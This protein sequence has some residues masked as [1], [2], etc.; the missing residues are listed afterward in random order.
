MQDGNGTLQHQLIATLDA[1]SERLTWYLL[2]VLQQTV[3]RGP[4]TPTMVHPWSSSEQRQD[5]VAT[6]RQVV[7]TVQCQR[8]VAE[9][10]V[11]STLFARSVFHENN[12]N[13]NNNNNKEI[14]TEL[15]FRWYV[16][17]RHALFVSSSE[18]ALLP[19]NLWEL[20]LAPFDEQ[21]AWFR[22]NG[23]KADVAKWR[24]QQQQQQQQQQLKLEQSPYSPNRTG[25][26]NFLHHLEHQSDDDALLSPRFLQ[27]WQQAMAHPVEETVATLRRYLVL[28]NRRLATHVAAEMHDRLGASSLFADT[29]CL[30][31]DDHVLPLTSW[32]GF[33][34]RLTFSLTSLTSFSSSS[35]C[36]SCHDVTTFLDYIP[37]HEAWTASVLLPCLQH[38]LWSFAMHI[39]GDGIEDGKEGKDE[40]ED[41]FMPI[42]L[43]D[44]GETTFATCGIDEARRLRRR[45]V[46]LWLEEQTKEHQKQEQQ[47]GKQK[48]EKQEQIEKKEATTTFLQKEEKEEE[49]DE[50]E[51]QVGF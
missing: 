43:D 46:C 30:L 32:F 5:L 9:V 1:H 44:T 45:R 29:W 33:L 15:V 34:R 16:K 6:F 2:H 51:E 14:V 25:L 22:A 39:I 7:H 47:E 49:E 26:E 12:N 41:D 10:S 31:T 3:A 27:C 37:Y 4:V 50:Q 38:V 19:S 21:V 20:P 17:A 36:S 42:V 18:R 28:S 13:N 8:R 23:I 40:D 48:E 35:T 24:Q 11:V